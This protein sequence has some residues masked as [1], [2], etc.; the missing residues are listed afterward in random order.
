MKVL[1]LTQPWAS[2]VIIGAKS[3]E[4]RSWSTSHRGPLLIHAGKR[5]PGWAKGVAGEEPFYSTLR[6]NGNYC[7]PELT[8]GHILGVVQVVDCRGTEEI[9]S[10]LGD[11]E[12][13]FGDYTDGRFAWLLSTPKRFPVP[14]AAKGHLGLWECEVSI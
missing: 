12:L 4:T 2:L 9:R 7:Y 11:Q 6:P 10:Q 1:S 3:V 5:F 13:L 8:C 14:V